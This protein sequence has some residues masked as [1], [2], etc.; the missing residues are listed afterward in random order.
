MLATT[1][2][3]ADL[4]ASGVPA[5]Q[6]GHLVMGNVIP[7]EPRDAY[8]GRVAAMPASIPKETPAFNVNRLSGSGLQAIIS[9]TQTILLGDTGIAIGAGAESMSRGAYI[10]PSASSAPRARSPKVV[11]RA[12][13]SVSKSRRARVRRCSRSTRTCAP[14][15]PLSSWRR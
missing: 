9:A 14:M 7:T 13:S 8:L 5:E 12:R 11:S 6:V 4:Q 1:A 3:K 10:L 2:V 15:F